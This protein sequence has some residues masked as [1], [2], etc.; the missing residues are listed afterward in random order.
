MYQEDLAY[1]HHV[2]FSDFMREAIPRLLILLQEAGITNGTVV[3][4]GCGGGLWLKALQ[5]AGYHSVGIDVSEPMLEIAKTESPLS[6]LIHQG[7]SSAKIPR[8]K[9][10][11]ALGEVLSYLPGEQG[12]EGFFKN[13]ACALDPGGLL[14]FDVLV[15]EDNASGMN[16][17][18]WR[19]GPDWAVLVK[20]SENLAEH[21][22]KREITSFRQM[23]ELYRRSEETHCLRVYAVEAIEKAL[24]QTEFSAFPVSSSTLYPVAPRRKVFVARKAL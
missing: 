16:Y 7:L 3:D 1:I 23:G 13:I 17:Q 22:L 6:V 8:C 21:T 15:E 19:T 2:G 12:L 5:D 11:T 20:A 4:L 24:L 14:I 9:A 10:I 18:S